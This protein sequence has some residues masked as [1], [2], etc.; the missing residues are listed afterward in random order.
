MQGQA[1]GDGVEVASDDPAFVYLAIHDRLAAVKV[2]IGKIGSDRIEEHEREGWHEVISVFMLGR[3]ARAV[4]AAVLDLWRDVLH[5]PYG[6]QRGDMRQAGYTETIRL[7]DRSM[8]K[9]KADLAAAASRELGPEP[10]Q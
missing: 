2:G 1:G 8:E 3:Q 5:L 4:E 7:A 10:P 9:A 6:V